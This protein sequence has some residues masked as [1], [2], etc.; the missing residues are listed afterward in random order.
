MAGLHVLLDCRATLG[1]SDRGRVCDWLE[2]AARTAGMHI[3]GLQSHLLPTPLDGGPG[4]SAVAVIAESHM[5]IHTWPE[6]GIITMDMFSCRPFDPVPIV[7]AFRECFGVTETLR[8]LE[9]PRWGL[10]GGQ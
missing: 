1:L 5:T 7:A 10:T 9:V 3:L 2:W 6:H 4:V 8:Y